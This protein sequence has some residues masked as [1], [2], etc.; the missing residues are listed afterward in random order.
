MKLDGTVVLFFR[1]LIFVLELL[2]MYV[3]IFLEKLILLQSC[4]LLQMMMM[5]MWYSLFIH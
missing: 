2:V 4:V 5:M 3:G 1:I